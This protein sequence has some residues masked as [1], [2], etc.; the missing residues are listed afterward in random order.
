MT[1][2]RQSEIIDKGIVSYFQAIE[3]EDMFDHL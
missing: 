1:Q 2:L 3:E